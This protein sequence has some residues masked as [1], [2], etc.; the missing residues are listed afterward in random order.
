MHGF[1]KR[2]STLEKFHEHC[3][4]CLEY[5]PQK[6]KY[7]EEGKKELQ[8]NDFDKQNPAAYIIYCDFETIL[9]HVK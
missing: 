8:F 1:I 9:V 5:G 4:N 2:H 7:P 3:E 6:V